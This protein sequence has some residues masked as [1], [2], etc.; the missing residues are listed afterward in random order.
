MPSAFGH[1]AVA[2]ALAPAVLGPGAPRRL[3]VSGVLCAVVP[4]AD[5]LFAEHRGVTHS[6]F[7]AALLALAVVWLAL[8]RG[9]PVS[10]GRAF[11]YLLLA[12]ASHGLLDTLTDG[13]AGVALFAPFDRTRVFAPFRPIAVSPLSVRRFLSERGL[14]VLWS[15]LVWLGIPALILVVSSRLVRGPISRGPWRTRRERS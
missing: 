4:D 10:R 13:G 1:A 15:E 14:A 7:A 8:P 11:A 2:L 9:S 5:V 12:S 6:L 3:L